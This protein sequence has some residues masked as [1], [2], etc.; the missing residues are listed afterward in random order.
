MEWIIS[1]SWNSNFWPPGDYFQVKTWFL[2][3]ENKPSQIYV[4]G[5]HS[6]AYNILKRKKLLLSLKIQI[7]GFQE[8][9]SRKLLLFLQVLKNMCKKYMNMGI[10]SKLM[11]LVGEINYFPVLKIKFPAS[12]RLFSG[13]QVIFLGT[14]NMYKIHVYGYHSEDYNIIRWINLFPTRQLLTRVPIIHQSIFITLNMME[15]SLSLFN[16]VIQI[17]DLMHVGIIKHDPLMILSDR[18]I[19]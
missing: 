19:N 9:D 14:K 10:I 4:Y 2:L 5:Y 8:A 12:R 15:S 6:K 7:Y 11:T 3:V 18:C 13:N 1:K 16:V 17:K